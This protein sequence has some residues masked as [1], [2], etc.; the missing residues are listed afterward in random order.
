MK[1]N[2]LK[3]QK[4]YNRGSQLKEKVFNTEDSVLWLQNNVREVGVIVGK[5]NTS[6]SY[7]VQDVKGNRF[8]RTSLHLKKKNK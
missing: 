2:Q 4:Y 7:I 6:R 1:E 3:Q 5:A 8:K